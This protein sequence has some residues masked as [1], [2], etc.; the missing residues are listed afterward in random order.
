MKIQLIVNQFVVDL[1]STFT[2][3]KLRQAGI[4]LTYFV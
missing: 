3:K 1:K 2:R 4:N